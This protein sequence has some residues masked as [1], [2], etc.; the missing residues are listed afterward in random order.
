[1]PLNGFVCSRQSG[2]GI[3]WV[4]GKGGLRE[5]VPARFFQGASLEKVRQTSNRWP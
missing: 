5:F 3:G 4:T 1:V 2:R